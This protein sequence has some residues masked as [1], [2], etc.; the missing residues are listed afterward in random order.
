MQARRG[1]DSPLGRFM[2]GLV[3]YP[4]NLLANWLF[5][6]YRDSAPGQV[7]MYDHLDAGGSADTFFLNSN[8]AFS[9]FG[10]IVTSLNP[11]PWG[12]A[13]GSYYEIEDV[14]MD[15]LRGGLMCRMDMANGTTFGQSL[16]CIELPDSTQQQIQRTDFDVTT[17]VMKRRFESWAGIFREKIEQERAGDLSERER[18]L[19]ITL[20]GWFKS[21]VKEDPEEPSVQPLQGVIS[22]YRWLFDKV[23]TLATDRDW[24]DFISQVNAGRSSVSNFYFD[25]HMQN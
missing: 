25:P 1:L 15:N 20:A 17:D 7:T 5:P 12:P 11:G 19:L 16:D 22:E 3:G 4:A 10:R 8:D 9:S 18:R 23:P 24:Q 21:V 6:T 14:A 13:H 2:G